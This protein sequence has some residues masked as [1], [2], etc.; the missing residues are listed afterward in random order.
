MENENL[1]LLQ[2]FKKQFEIINRNYKNFDKEEI[3]QLRNLRKELEELRKDRT[4]IFSKNY[5]DI[6]KYI[7]E[8]KQ[9]INEINEVDYLN[10]VKAI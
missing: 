8:K 3:Q 1:I 9:K 6:R 5:T 2:N 7:D 10:W 4:E